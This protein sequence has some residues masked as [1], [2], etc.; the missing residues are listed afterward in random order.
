M[1]LK[2]SKES[3]SASMTEKQKQLFDKTVILD[4][5]SFNIKKMVE[6]PTE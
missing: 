3:A 1:K 4:K 5:I 2:V 6:I